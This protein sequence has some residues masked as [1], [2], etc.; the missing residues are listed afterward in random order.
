MEKLKIILW[1]WYAWYYIYTGFQFIGG[2]KCLFYSNFENCTKEFRLAKTSLSMFGIVWNRN[3]I[4]KNNLRFEENMYY[5]DLPFSFK[6]IALSNSYKIKLDYIFTY[7]YTRN[8]I[9]SITSKK[10]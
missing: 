5:E 4:L 1:L 7:N 9:G 10:W 6:G 8:R 3:F 2:E